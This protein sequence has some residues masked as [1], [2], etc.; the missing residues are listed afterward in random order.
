MNPI[1]KFS[2]TSRAFCCLLAALQ[3]GAKLRHGDFSPE[4]VR[5]SLDASRWRIQSGLQH[6]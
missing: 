4:A 3:S 6:K 5:R 1:F 2:G